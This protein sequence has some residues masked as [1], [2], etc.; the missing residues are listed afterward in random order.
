V[1]SFLQRGEQVFT[2]K[3]ITVTCRP[4]WLAANASAVLTG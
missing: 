4:G 3:V 1:I 2:V